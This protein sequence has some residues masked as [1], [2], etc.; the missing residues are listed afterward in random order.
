MN[1]IFSLCCII[2]G[3]ILLVLNAIG[4]VVPM[5]HADIDGYVDFANV[6]NATASVTLEKLANLDNRQHQVSPV[7]FV[8]QATRIFHEGIAHVER[9]DVRTNGHAYYGMT[10]PITENW[11]LFT[12]RYLKPDTYKDYE[13]CSY[14]KAIERGTG[15]C[16]QQSLA[17]VSYLSSNQ[18]NTGFV[19][20]GGHAIASAEVRPDEWYLLDPDFGGV[21][22]FDIRTAE[23][24]TDRI[25]DYYWNREVA[26]ERNLDRTFLPDNEFKEGGV[27]ARFGR[28]CYIESASYIAKWAVP[29]V[30]LIAGVGVACWRRRL[31]V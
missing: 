21:I 28:A 6:S 1:R 10:V 29:L 23:Q 27:E 8:T 31:P 26:E 25:L 11:I 18:I 3:V 4:L 22:P 20:L 12:L 19:A 7:E 16:G 13:F 30:L 17:L 9:S 14:R 2:S 24:N 5:R 15:R